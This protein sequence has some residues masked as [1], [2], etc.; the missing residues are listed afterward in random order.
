M[1]CEG[2]N[3]NHNGDY[4][5][6]FGYY[7]KAAELGDA[8]AHYQLSTLY[9]HGRGVEKDEKKELHHMEE[10]AIGGHPN[11]RY[12][13]GYIEGNN[14]KAERAKKHW[15]IAATQGNDLSIGMLM[16][17][18][19]GGLVSK[20]VLATALRAHH[21]AV[22]ATKSSQREAAEEYMRSSEVS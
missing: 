2:L 13:I 6:A 15:N 12:S 22:D 20:E 9:H 14:G 16:N 11:A 4:S 19:K 8:E 18:F 3:Q 21:A 1:T 5:S 10:A 17:I 7:T